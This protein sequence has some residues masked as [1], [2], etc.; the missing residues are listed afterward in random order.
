M[1]ASQL[2]AEQLHRSI[3]RPAAPST[4]AA[5][6]EERQSA[7]FTSLANFPVPYLSRQLSSHKLG[8]VWSLL[9]LMRVC[10]WPVTFHPFLPPNWPEGGERQWQGSLHHKT[11]GGHCP[12]Q[13]PHNITTTLSTNK[14][15]GPVCHS[16][17]T[18]RERDRKGKR[19]RKGVMRKTEEWGKGGLRDQKLR[20]KRNEGSRLAPGFKSQLF[21]CG[22]VW[23][24]CF[25]DPD[26]VCLDTE[27]LHKVKGR[28]SM[29]EVRLVIA[30]SELSL[31]TREAWHFSVHVTAPPPN[32]HHHGAFYI[33]MTSLLVQRRTSPLCFYCSVC[34]QPL[35][36]HRGP[37]HHK[38]L[39]TN[40][41]VPSWSL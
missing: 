32:P 10:T 37:R 30:T 19:G 8:S 39:N 24:L 26:N 20:G 3:W 2:T 38:Q 11:P 17:Q 28:G 41:Y 9:L 23:H 14:W 27:K 4:S 5:V 40:H 34:S 12:Q 22:N 15:T 33:N 6:V 31:I 18:E 21:S 13:L 1:R 16:A 7:S 35:W 36:L 29:V 25:H